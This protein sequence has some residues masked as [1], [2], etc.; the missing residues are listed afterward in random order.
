LN[1]DWDELVVE[2]DKVIDYMM[3]W[4]GNR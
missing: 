4:F 3:T 2:L 1:L